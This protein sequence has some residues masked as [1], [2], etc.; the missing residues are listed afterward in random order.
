MEVPQGRRKAFFRA[1]AAALRAFTPP[2][3]VLTCERQLRDA[4]L[5]PAQ[6]APHSPTSTASATSPVGNGASW[7]C[8]QTVR[9]EHR[10]RTTSK[11]STVAAG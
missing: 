9:P 11:E 10:E 8:R 4:R 5:D 1:S 7:I 6:A 2:S 3:L